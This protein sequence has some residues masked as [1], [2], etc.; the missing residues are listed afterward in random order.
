M[1]LWSSASVC[2]C[3]RTAA[4]ARRNAAL[5]SAAKVMRCTQ[6]SLAIIVIITGN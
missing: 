5:V 6:C 2:L 3:V 1:V 4:T